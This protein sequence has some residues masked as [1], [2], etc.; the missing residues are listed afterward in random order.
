MSDN[1]RDP[2]IDMITDLI[3]HYVRD[4]GARDEHGPAP[5]GHAQSNSASDI[6]PSASQTQR[7]QGSSTQASQ[8]HSMGQ[9]E[10][11]K[12]YELQ[13][14]KSRAQLIQ[15]E[16]SLCQER[17]P[18]IA[19]RLRTQRECLVEKIMNLEATIKNLRRV[20]ANVNNTRHR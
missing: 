10:V 9:S 6:G 17:N 19:N 7:A 2:A 18:I 1:T 4:Q 13:I 16:E 14:K 3:N 15:V 11:A 20:L 5:G 8:S 12:G